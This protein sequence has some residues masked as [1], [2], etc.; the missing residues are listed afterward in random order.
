[1]KPPRLATVVARRALPRDGSGRSVL[2]DLQQELD[3]RAAREGTGRA[4]RWYWRQAMSIW[5]WSAW[6]HPLDSHHQPRGG[7]MFDI[8]G[9]VRQAIRGAIKTPGQTALIVLTFA[10]LNGLWA[11]GILSVFAMALGTALTVSVLATLAVTAKN[12]AVAAAGD[13][14]AGHRRPW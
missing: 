3:E 9:D 6:A 1:M 13:G 14:R 10:F 11:G 2:G 7:F 4:R 12:W 8:I 5:L